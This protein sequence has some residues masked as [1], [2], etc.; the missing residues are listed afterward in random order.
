MPE[1]SQGAYD[2]RALSSYVVYLEKSS[3]LSGRSLQSA[4]KD[5]QRRIAHGGFYIWR[6]RR[7][8]RPTGLGGGRILARRR[9]FL[10]IGNGSCQGRLIAWAYCRCPLFGLR[11]GLRIMGRGQMSVKKRVVSH[12]VRKR[13]AP[14]TV[15]RSH[16][17]DP[18]SRARARPRRHTRKWSGVL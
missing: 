16:R 2:A 8:A 3:S 4:G 17:R 14:A 1:A 9:E 12:Q 10:S 18:R 5:P 15:P 7:F 13:S 11:I 6:K